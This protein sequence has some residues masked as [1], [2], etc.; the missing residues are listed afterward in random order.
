VSYRTY[1]E[2]ADDYKPNLKILEGHFCPYYTSWDQTV[3]DTTRVNQWK[4]EFDSLLKVNAVPQLNTLRIINDH[5]E[6]MSLGRPTPFA[7]VADNDWAIGLFVE[8]LSKSPIWEQSVVFIVEDDAQNGPDHVDAHRTT[9]YVAGGYVKR[10]FIDHTPYSTSSMVRT[11]E[12]IL[13]MRPMSQYDAAATPMWRSF[14]KTPNTKPFQSLPARVD[15]TEVNR[16]DGPLARKSKT[17]DFSKEDRVNDF[18]F[19]EVIWKGVRGENSEM[20]APKRSAF[21]RTIDVDDK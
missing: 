8:H 13:G 4:R 3:R 18:E 19:S 11:I 2:F 14:S 15:I 16:K 12:L 9:A 10:G 17:F 7:H 1:G 6:G 21:V 20:P 5:T